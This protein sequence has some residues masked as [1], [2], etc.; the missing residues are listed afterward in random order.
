M[1]GDDFVIIIPDHRA[2]IGE[3][4]DRIMTYVRQSGGTAGFLPAFG[5]YGIEDMSMSISTMY[6]RAC[7]ALA[8]VKGSYARRM[9]RYDSRMMREMEENH[10]LLSEVQKGLDHGEF[11]F[12][13]QPKCCLDTGRIV[14]LEAL[15]RWNH[16]VRGLIPPGV[17]LPLLENNGLITK[18]DLFIWEEV[19]RK[20]RRWIDRGHKMCIRDRK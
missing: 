9:C 8:S 17:F 7:I 5:I 20:L 11:V 2:A 1:G 16:P 4:Q 12:Y 6:D 10:K 19:C 18:L 13:A 15:V 14:G 3:L